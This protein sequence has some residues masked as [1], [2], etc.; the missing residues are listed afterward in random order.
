MGLLDWMKGGRRIL[1]ADDDEAARGFVADMLTLEG[2]EVDTAADGREALEKVKR[3]GYAL[4]VLD[5]KMPKL[6]GLQVLEA[7][8]GP[9]KRGE[10]KVIML[11][12]EKLS[13]AAMKAYEHGA[14]DYIMK[15]FGPR[16]LAEKVKACFAGK[17]K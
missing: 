12:A 2:Y 5:I 14:V 3:G 4:L 17:G 9:I 7:V 10:L 1:V 8:G 13:G 11:T 6:D 15:P 16:D